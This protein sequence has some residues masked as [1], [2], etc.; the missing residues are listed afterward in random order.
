[1][2]PLHVTSTSYS[3]V[4]ALTGGSQEEVLQEFQAEAT[5]LL[6]I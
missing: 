2:W 3:M 5:S 6:M 4:L 1:M